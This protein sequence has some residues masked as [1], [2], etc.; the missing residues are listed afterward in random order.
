MTE[1]LK[2]YTQSTLPTDE[3]I[4]LLDCSLRSDGLPRTE[5]DQLAIKKMMKIIFAYSRKWKP[6]MDALNVDQE[7]KE[8]KKQLDIP[9]PP[10]LFD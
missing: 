7:W 4:D 5:H 1:K 3:E 2:E 6:S 9:D 8:T 10:R